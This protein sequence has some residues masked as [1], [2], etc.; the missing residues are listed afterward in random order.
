[1]N[2][3][4]PSGIIKRRLHA[5]S[6]RTPLARMLPDESFKALALEA[7]RAAWPCKN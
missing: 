6:V 5:A 7:L 2:A 1:M 4:V 3:F